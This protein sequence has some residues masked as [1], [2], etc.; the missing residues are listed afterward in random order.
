MYVASKNTSAKATSVLL[1]L[2][3]VLSSL[4]LTVSPTVQA[5]GANQND[6][7]SGGDLPDNTSVGISNYIFSGSYSDPFLP[8]FNHI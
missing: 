6:L 4:M 5:V 7:N 3:M 8:F 1:T 2:M